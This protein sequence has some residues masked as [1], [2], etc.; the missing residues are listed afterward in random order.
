MSAE[1]YAHN[2]GT[3]LIN[4]DI[5][6]FV[7]DKAE[8][9]KLLEEI[10]YD[11]KKPTILVGCALCQR[12]TSH[13]KKYWN[14]ED[15]VRNNLVTVFAE[16]VSSIKPEA[17][18]MEN[19]PEFLSKR[20]RK[21]FAAAKSRYEQEDYVVKES[22]Y[23]A[24]SFGVPQERFRSVVIGMKKNFLLPKGYLSPMEYKTVRDAIGKL[25]P[26]PAGVADPNDPMHKSELHK[27]AL[28]M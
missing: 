3:P 8:L 27:K 7:N 20:Y 15:D 13:R 24:A 11:N 22:I 9:R 6:D 16:I 19:V 4:R 21:Y 26:V 1:T 25:P 28:W 17:F 23:N 18:V 2:F 5:T 12:F 14:E 10:G